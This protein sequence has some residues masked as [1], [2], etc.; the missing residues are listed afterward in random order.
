MP[1]TIEIV[2]M[3]LQ[4]FWH[5]NETKKQLQSKNMKNLIQAFNLHAKRL[6]LFRVAVAVAAALTFLS[7]PSARASILFSDGFNY[8]AA[9]QLGNDGSW[10]SPGAGVTVGTTNLGTY[11]SGSTLA[12]FSP[13]GNDVYSVSG[14]SVTTYAPLTTSVSSGTVYCSFL[15]KINATATSSGIGMAGLLATGTTSASSGNASDAF[16]LVWTANSGTTVELYAAGSS[17]SHSGTVDLG[18]VGALHLVVVQYVI[19]TGVASLYLDP[20]PGGNQPGSPNITVTGTAP[21]ITLGNFYIKNSST[22]YSPAFSVD[23]LRIGT[24][25]ADV[26]PQVPAS[27]PNTIISANPTTLLANGTSQSAITVQAY[28]TNDLTMGASGGSVTLSASTG[29]LGTVTDNGNGTYTATYTSP[30]SAGSG[31]ATISGTING[32]TIGYNATITLTSGAT[33]SPNFTSISANSTSIIANGT[34][35]STITVQARGSDGNNWNTGGATVNLST[36]TGTL[37]AN[38]AHD[39]G[40]GTY[41]ATL[42]SPTTVGAAI[43]SGTIN[44]GAIGTNAT[45]SLIPGPVSAGNTVIT[46]AYTN[47]LA[48]GEGS[49]IIAVQA[50]DAHN[51]SLTNSGGTVTL[52]ASAGSLL[53]GTGSPS[54]VTA[55][56]NGNGTYAATLTSAVAPGSAT[57]S[58]T[59]GGS[60]IGNNATVTFSQ[61]ALLEGF[62]YT[63]GTTLG[64]NSP[65]TASETGITVSSTNLAYRSGSS[66]AD[67]NPPGNAA[68]S[69]PEVSGYGTTY[70]PLSATTA[71][72]TNSLY[73]SFLLDVTALMTY[74]S[75][76]VPMCGLMA[77]S[78]TTKSQ[79]SAT[80]AFS[81]ITRTNG[82]GGWQI[83]LQ[84]ANGGAPQT[85]APV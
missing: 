40:N 68:Q 39:N 80:E 50:K 25:W 35:T 66:L 6:P 33:L 5:C 78:Q 16:N 41:T 47:L 32:N 59:I 65:W 31:S 29:S 7:G 4:Q 54:T 8:T 58:G 46:A 82:A 67:F 21:A 10:K 11:R 13:V 57:L 18:P 63:S 3:R 76:T 71:S 74:P 2:L 30:S 26:T 84:V 37:S 38:P 24:T 23:T 44:S 85:T 75:Y 52:T 20:T 70:I 34:S 42:T 45:V 15:V 83:A 62:N 53:G 72:G 28:D 48:N 9:T 61:Y 19:S 51:N 60:A 43:I 22:G 36:T 27:G 64:S 69:A 81:L 12:D 56:D 77:A 1:E 17:S 73:C 14:T 79:G 55:T 49:T